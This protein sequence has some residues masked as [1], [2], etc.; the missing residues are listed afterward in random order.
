MKELSNDWAAR[1]ELAAIA[2]WTPTMFF[3]SYLAILA[4]IMT[5]MFAEPT[6]GDPDVPGEIIPLLII[7]AIFG[8]IPLLLL[9][10][11]GIALQYWVVRPLVTNSSTADLEPLDEL[12][13]D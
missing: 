13:D 9:T 8:L 11:I 10:T 1:L 12:I 6:L 7:C 3:G 5:G 4:F 2:F